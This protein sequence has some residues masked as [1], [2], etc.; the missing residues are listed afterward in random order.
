MLRI[1]R[2][3]FIITLFVILSLHNIVYIALILLICFCADL[4]NIKSI[5]RKVL[6]SIFIFNFAITISYS[7]MYFFRED[8][9]L[10]YLLY[11]NLKVYTITYFV[12][13]FFRKVDMVQFFAFSKDLSFLLIVTLSQIISYKKSFYDLKTA[14]QARVIKKLRE[15]E[16]GFIIRVFEFFFTKAMKDSKERALAMKARGLFD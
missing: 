5:N 1:H 16:K 7:I 4:R 14:F 3:L 2:V 8:L 10:W 9:N 12:T 13:L 6:K 15:R 11:I